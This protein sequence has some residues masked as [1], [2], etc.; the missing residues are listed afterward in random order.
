MKKIKVLLEDDNEILGNGL[1]HPIYRQYLPTIK[2]VNL[3]NKYSIKSTFYI[4]MGHYL[5]LKENIDFHDFRFQINSIEETIKFLIKNNMNVQIHLHSQWVDAKIIDDKIFV[6]DKWNIGQ[7]SPKNQTELF[8]NAFSALKN[9]LDLENKKNNLNSF[10]A[11]SWG[12]QPFS[13][14]YD[15]FKNRG[16]KIVMGPIKGLKVKKLGID[17]TNL[18]SDFFPYYASKNDINKVNS[19]AGPVVLPMTPTY[20]NWIDLIRYV[21][22]ISIFK[23]FHKSKP[24]DIETIPKRIQKLKPLS[25]KDKLTFGLKPFTTH[26]K[27]NAQ[28]YWYLKKTFIRSYKMIKE[29]NFDYKLMVIETHTKDFHNNFED[30]DLFFD[31]LKNNYSDLEF[32]TVDDLISDIETKKISPLNE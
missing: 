13:T 23:F 6:T 5:F 25:G 27:I 24:I 26:L 14:L 4:D 17:Y 15:L 30:I 32:I 2:Y 29:S 31:Y 1:G 28:K 21:F 7:L 8:E 10:K 20:L 9:I 19:Y 12:L 3:L 11:G 18:H 22:E 16:I